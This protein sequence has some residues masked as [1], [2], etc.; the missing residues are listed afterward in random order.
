MYLPD[1]ISSR[2]LDGMYQHTDLELSFRN[3]FFLFCI[4]FWSLLL[5]GP[6]A[7]LVF[8]DTAIDPCILPWVVSKEETRA[9]DI[10]V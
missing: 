4:G 2:R 8:P 1:L 10:N 9:Q 3:L 6:Q 5:P 7:T